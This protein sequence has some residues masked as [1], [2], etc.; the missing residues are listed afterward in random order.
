MEWR[1]WLGLQCWPRWE[2][3]GR[4]LHRSHNSI[5][6][7]FRISIS[8]AYNKCKRNNDRF[9]NALLCQ[10][11]NEC[12]VCLHEIKKERKKE[13]T[14]HLCLHV[15]I[16]LISDGHVKSSAGDDRLHTEH[17]ACK[18]CRHWNPPLDVSPLPLCGLWILNERK[19][20]RMNEWMNEWKRIN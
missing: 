6:C 9:F 8:I 18:W 14:W 2:G 1:R 4:C 7:T 11:Y 13:C 5:R 15:V 16:F 10:L 19:K 3:G 20:G 12:Y 17:R